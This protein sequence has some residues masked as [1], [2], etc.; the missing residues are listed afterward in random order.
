M[1]I[2]LNLPVRDLDPK[3]IYKGNEMKLHY[4]IMTM[5]LGM[6]IS[7][8][9]ALAQERNFQGDVMVVPVLP[10]AP[11]LST[12]DYP[13]CRED[14]QKIEAPFER[15][16]DINRC[17]ELLD[18]FYDGKLLP[19]ADQ[20]IAHQTELSRLYSEEVAGNPTL[21]PA[22]HDDFYARMRTEFSK[23]EPNGEYMS[24]YQAAVARYGA[25]R[26]YLQDRFCFNTGCNGYPV[27]EYT[28]PEPVQI[29]A[30]DDDGNKKDKS[31]KSKK[32]K[33]KKTANKGC[34][35]AR[36]RGGFLGSVLGGVAGQAA[37]LDGIG[38][39]LAAGVGGILV[40][41]IACQLT[42]E[43]QE[44]AVKA[45]K[46]VTEAEAVGAT[47]EWKSPS[48][49]GVSGSSTVTA[50]ASRPNGRKCMTITDIAIID[51]E[52]TRIEKQMC[53][54]RGDKAYVLEA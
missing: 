31:K 10:D 6:S 33:K 13:E 37:G 28:P 4:F 35:R 36:K 54:S 24:D 48:R 11:I 17:T 27:P 41:E 21:T 49:E 45:T 40:G 44:E 30:N 15:A 47:A 23:S 43:E 19:F 42:K 32:S 12:D 2:I 25:D 18:R 29:A 39:L 14:W 22:V 8:Q 5:L 51:G 50:L 3:V 1:G 38:S 34:G 16:N 53:K 7:S 46:K 9:T 52:E 20:M 26:E